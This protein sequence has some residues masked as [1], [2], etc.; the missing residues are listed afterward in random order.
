MIAL[1]VRE[2]A[3]MLERYASIDRAGIAVGGPVDAR[4]GLVLGPP[5]LP[6]WDRIPLKDLLTRALALPTSIEHDAKAGALAEWKFGAGR[7]VEN[8]VFLTLGTGLGAGI[9]A[10]GRL[11]R[12]AG[13]SAGEIGHWR[14]SKDGPLAYGKAGSLEGWASGAG[15]PLLARFL[16]EGTLSEAVSA[17]DIGQRASSGDAAALRVV[18]RSG[19]ALGFALAKVADLLAPERIVLGSLASRLG[20]PFTDPLREAFRAEAL[21]AIAARCEIVCGELGERIG[22]MAALAVAAQGQEVI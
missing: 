14:A 18:A 15:L 4:R 3:A 17:R 16:K 1:I 20:A 21:A 22:D 19:K 2:A 7:G 6:G 8:M 13:N 12:G 5:N 10:D 9:I 11:L